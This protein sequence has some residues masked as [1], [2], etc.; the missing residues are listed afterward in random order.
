MEDNR[1][2]KKW[3]CITCGFENNTEHIDCKNFKTGLNCGQQ[4]PYISVVGKVDYIGKQ[5]LIKNKDYILRELGKICKQAE[6]KIISKNNQADTVYKM[7]L[8][9]LK[10][11]AEIK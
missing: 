10:N 4:R 2:N 11:D 5:R 3:R 8:D 9:L 6:E 1:K 7:K